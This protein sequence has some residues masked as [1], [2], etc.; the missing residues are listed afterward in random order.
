LVQACT[1]T[2]SGVAVAAGV[3]VAVEGSG[4]SAAV[5]DAGTVRL[6]EADLGAPDPH[7]VRLITTAAARQPK[8]NRNFT[9]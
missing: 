1:E 9:R 7:P 8:E 6:G 3:A 4:E 5:A 2:G